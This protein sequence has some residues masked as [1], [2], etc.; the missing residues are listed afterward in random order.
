MWS[1]HTR[2]KISKLPYSMHGMQ[3]YPCSR[4]RHQISVH[5]SLRGRQ[6]PLKVIQCACCAI[7]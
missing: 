2:R 5:S 1:P 3:Y 6:C 7:N 4:R